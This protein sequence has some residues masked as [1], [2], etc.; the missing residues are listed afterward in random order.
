M[1]GEQFDALQ[2]YRAGVLAGRHIEKMVVL[3]EMGEGRDEDDQEFYFRG[4]FD[5]VADIEFV[6]GRFLFAV[7][8][9]FSDHTLVGWWVGPDIP[10]AHLQKEMHR[11]VDHLGEAESVLG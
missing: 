4:P 2:T 1:S 11:A 8:E 3:V 6:E 9:K 10:F 5:V 7:N